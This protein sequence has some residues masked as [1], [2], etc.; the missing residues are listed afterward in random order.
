M[1]NWKEKLDSLQMTFGWSELEYKAIESLV[2]QGMAEAVLL[3]GTREKAYNLGR[4]EVITAIVHFI[5]PY[6]SDED[7][8]YNIDMRE[9]KDFLQSLLSNNQNEV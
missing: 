1:N 4:E 9:F 6:K 3:E 2:E 5:T 8:N 7:G